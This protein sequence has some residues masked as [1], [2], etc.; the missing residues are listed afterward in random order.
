MFGDGAPNLDN[1]YVC[2]VDRQ[3]VALAAVISS[4]LFIPGSYLPIFLFPKVHRR[5][6]VGAAF[7]SEDYAAELI[8]S[9]ASILINNA[10]ARMGGYEYLILAGLSEAQKSFLILPEQS[11]IIEIADISGVFAGLS[12]I[13][14]TEKKELRCRTSEI[15]LGLFV[16]ERKQRKLVIDEGAHALPEVVDLRKG[17]VVVEETDDAS[18]VL[19]VNY[20]SSIYASVLIVKSFTRSEAREIQKWIHQWK[21]NDEISHFEKLA[22]A[23][24]LRIGGISFSQFEYATFF[25]EGLPYALVLE[26]CI[27]CSHVHLSLKPDLLILNSILFKNGSNFHGAVVFSPVFFSDEETDSLCDL[28][29]ER[30]FFLHPLVGPDATLANL[31]FYAQHFPYDVL[32][33][34][35]HG[36]EV[37]GY[38]MSGTFVDREGKEHLVEFEEVVGVAPVP[39]DPA[40]VA[41]H[42]KVFLR[43]LD[44]IA[45]MSAELDRQ[46]LPQKIYLD[47]WKCALESKGRRTKKG[48]IEMSCAIACVDSIHQGEFHT[49]ASHSSPLVFNNTCWSAH[50]VSAFFLACGARGYIGTLWA[51]DNQAAVSAAR[52]FYESVFSGSIL[53][54]FHKAI[55]SIDS[56][57][58]KDI[59][60]YWGLHFT[61]L[62]PAQRADDSRERV[63]KELKHAAVAW[64]K[65]IESA[66]SEEIRRNSVRVLRLILATLT[67]EFDSADVRKLDA[68]ITKRVSDLSTARG[69]D[70]G[71]ESPTLSRRE[72]STERPVEFRKSGAPSP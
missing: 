26:N 14:P 16:A 13:L 18:S 59:Y 71:G 69:S 60:I 1:R 10:L 57:T 21:Q 9:P 65:K 56:T 31:D 36:G 12:D 8:A 68:A 30:S 37:E 64:V 27:P 33:L 66:E 11:H 70:L 50:D 51:I 24:R 45:W 63:C 52:T 41:V 6:A 34:C 44:G 3:A 28:F 61:S 55:K 15:L 39:D 49:L 32:H 25:T 40:M 46:G 5:K 20:A 48:L 43:K 19:A 35:S 62:P 53:D 7:M 42:R 29:T 22:K 2:I 72:P 54:A 58:S 47:A 67:A 17:M 38:E 23:V 4:Y